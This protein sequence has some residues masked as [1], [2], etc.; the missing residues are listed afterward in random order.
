MDRKRILIT[1]ACSLFF[2]VLYCIEYCVLTFL[3]SVHNHT[4]QL[5]SFIYPAII[6]IIGEKIHT[7]TVSRALFPFIILSATVPRHKRRP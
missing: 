7:L 4:A 1:H 3:L 6:F 5:Y 2:I